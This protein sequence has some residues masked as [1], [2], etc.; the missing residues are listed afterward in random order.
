MGGERFIVQ[1]KVYKEFVERVVRITKQLKQGPVLGG[2]FVD[3]GAICLPGLPE[4]VC[5]VV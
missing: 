1:S 4:K 5:L 2:A 3:C